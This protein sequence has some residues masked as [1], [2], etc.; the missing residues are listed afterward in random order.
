MIELT[1]QRGQ[2]I[3]PKTDTRCYNY[4]MTHYDLPQQICE[5]VDN[6]DV[7]VQ[8]GGN[9]GVYTKMYAQQFNHVYTF[10]PEPLNFFCLNQNVT[11]SN[12]YKYQSCIGKDR[13][14]V[15]LKIKEANR[16]KNHVSKT[17]SIPTLQIDDLGLTTCNLIHLDVEGFELFALLG[18]IQTIRKCKPVI[19]VEYFE[20]NAARYNWNLE[21][22]ES[23]LRQHGYKLAHTIEEERIYV[24][25]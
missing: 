5:Y 6:K 4:M 13:N 8:A 25:Q 20:K 14:L 9:M 12:V 17:G 2:Y 22:L 1:E 18:S 15:N 21:Q 11:E 24:A 16:G 3:W 23:F 10:E 19:V 7:C